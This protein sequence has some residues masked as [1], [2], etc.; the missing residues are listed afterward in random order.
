MRT[1]LILLLFTS[2]SANAQGLLNRIPDKLNHY[3]FSCNFASFGSIAIFKM[4]DRPVLSCVIATTA[5]IALGA[6]KEGYW[7]GYLHRGVKD[8]Q[9]DFPA[10]IQGALV[11]GFFA[12]MSIV[13]KKNHEQDIELK[14][15]N[16]A[17]P[18]H[19]LIDPEFIQP[20][21]VIQIQDS[22]ILPE[23]IL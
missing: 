18:L 20:V 9:G 1:I 21:Q 3:A 19:E 15:A 7:D 10:D 12:G 8:W 22:L 2:L 6:L 11:G 4:T 5:S 14:Y 13:L 16:M 23:I 17:P